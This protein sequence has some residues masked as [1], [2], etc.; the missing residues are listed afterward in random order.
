M[1]ASQT[2]QSP[3]QLEIQV[4]FIKAYFWQ[5][6]EKWQEHKRV[7]ERAHHHDPDAK[8]ERMLS[9]MRLDAMLDEYLELDYGKAA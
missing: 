4:D 5:E 1:E 8:R 6:A 7:D 3:T 9:M 2:S